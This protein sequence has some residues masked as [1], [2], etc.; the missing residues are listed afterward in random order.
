LAT[1]LPQKRSAAAWL[2]L[3][4]SEGLEPLHSFYLP[5]PAQR[6]SRWGSDRPCRTALRLRLRRALVSTCGVLRLDLTHRLLPMRG[7]LA[8]GRAGALKDRIGPLPNAIVALA[9]TIVSFLD[10]N[11]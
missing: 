3:Q 10:H 8:L 2:R 1:L 5:P 11:C 6:Y 9:D 7:I 4:S